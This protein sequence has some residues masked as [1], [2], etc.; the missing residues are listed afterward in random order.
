MTR[1]LAAA[2]VA[3]LVAATAASAFAVQTTTFGLQASGSRPKIVL[4]AGN[5]TVHD[6]VVVYN[7]TAA[8]IT[9][10]LGAVGVTRSA[11]GGYNL[12][13]SGAGLARDITL[14]AHS[15]TLGP[16]ARRTIDVAVH[17]PGSSTA[18]YAAVTALANAT[19]NGGLSVTERLAVL[20]VLPAGHSGSGG[21]TARIV[22]IVIATLAL[23]ATAALWVR[24]RK[25]AA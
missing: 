21:G 22:A 15:V 9:I 19:G 13:A 25:R 24:R 11:N 17:R 6:S 3:I 12:G 10:T 20:V 2:L 1:R 5:G 18:Q 23:A 4:P 8:P 16:K 7:R 14:A